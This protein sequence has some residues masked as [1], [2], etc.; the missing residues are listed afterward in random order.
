MKSSLVCLASI[1]CFSTSRAES[2]CIQAELHNSSA[3]LNNQSTE[4]SNKLVSSIQNRTK[5]IYGELNEMKRRIVEKIVLVGDLLPH[6]SEA[7]LDALNKKLNASDNIHIDVT[8]PFLRPEVQRVV[9]YLDLHFFG[10]LKR[11]VDPTKR[12]STFCECFTRFAVS[13]NTM[14]STVIDRLRTTIARNEEDFPFD[15][16]TVRTNFTE[17]FVKFMMKTRNMCGNDVQCLE[18][19]VRKFNTFNLHQLLTKIL[20]SLWNRSGI[21]QVFSTVTEE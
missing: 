8:K 13:F 20:N 6:S 18:E 14:I 2:S 3:W 1:I 4:L 9:S 11:F 19:H 7:L 5:E 17:E 10:Q 12:N 16:E 21:F 15:D